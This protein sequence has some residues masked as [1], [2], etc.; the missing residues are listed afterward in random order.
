MD[1]VFQL[2][3]INYNVKFNYLLLTFYKNNF[4][5]IKYVTHIH[6]LGDVQDTLDL[7]KGNILS[8]QMTAITFLND[9]YTYL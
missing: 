9:Q 8:S 2:D 3:I 1:I 4:I 6:I 5:K 7:K